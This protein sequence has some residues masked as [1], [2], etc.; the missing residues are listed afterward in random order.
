MKVLTLYGRVV[1]AMIG[2]EY[3][4]Q[5]GEVRDMTEGGAPVHHAVQDAAQGPYVRT[6]RDLSTTH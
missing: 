3:G 4:G 2:V 5:L 6:E 1:Y